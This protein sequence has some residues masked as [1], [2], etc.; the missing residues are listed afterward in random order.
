V[1]NSI[2]RIVSVPRDTL[3][4]SRLNAGVFCNRKH[5]SPTI[6]RR[7]F[8]AIV[9]NLLLWGCETWA[10]TKQQHQRLESCFN[11][12]IRAMTGT[13]WK[14]IRENRISNSPSVK[15]R[16]I[17]IH[18]KKFMQPVVSIGLRNWQKRSYACHSIKFSSPPHATWRL[19][20]WW[21]TSKG[22]IPNILPGRYACHYIK[23][24]APPHA[25]WCLVF[26]WQTSK[27]YVPDILPVELTSTWLISSNSTSWIASLE[28]IKKANYVVYLI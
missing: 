9:I 6:R 8:M 15:N 2:S 4:Y 20:F 27:G 23:F 1:V 3:V 21:Q 14:E 5:L 7:L 17:L 11:K 13:R 25:T 28:T 10:L 26:W 19:V 16:I 22:Y 12:W 18:W 24:S